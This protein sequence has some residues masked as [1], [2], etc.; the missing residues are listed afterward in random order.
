MLGIPAGAVKET[1][2]R[3]VRTTRTPCSSQCLVLHGQRRDAVA[4]PATEE[5]VAGYLA[6]LA[7]A[8]L[9]S[10]TIARRLVVISPA[11]RVTATCRPPRVSGRR[12]E[13]RCG[14]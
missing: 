7:A 12:A 6:E 14:V 10:A 2:V 1:P 8:S 5:T 11:H 13:G 3:F 9:K 4:L